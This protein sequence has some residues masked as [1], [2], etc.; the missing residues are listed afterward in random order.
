M[1]HEE[2]PDEGV[3]SV[4]VHVGDVSQ[5]AGRVVDRQPLAVVLL[6]LV[7]EEVGH[8]GD[9]LRAVQDLSHHLR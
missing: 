4:R 3:V 5:R 6:V 1:F 2:L 8:P 7:V 9:V